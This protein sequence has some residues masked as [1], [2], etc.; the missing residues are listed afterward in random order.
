MV[1]FIVSL[2]RTR[3]LGHDSVLCVIV[4]F[5]EIYVFG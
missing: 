2:W 1:L 3:I 4:L 5:Y